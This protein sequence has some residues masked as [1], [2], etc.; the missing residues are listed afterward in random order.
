MAL[1]SFLQRKPRSEPARTAPAPEAAEALRARARRRLIGAALLLGLGV[2]VFGLLFETRPRPMPVDL[3]MVIKPVERL[4]TQG[5][6]PAVRPTAVQRA[7]APASAPAAAKGVETPAAAAP[8][9]AV[10]EPVAAAAPPASAQAPGRAAT[11]GGVAPAAPAASTPAAPAA[12]A[13]ADGKTARF[14]VQVG[15][16]AEASAAR[17][18]RLA[19]EKLGFKTYTQ[20]VETE[21]GKRTR[22]RVGPYASRDEAAKALAKIRAANLPGAVLAL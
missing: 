22:V 18:A 16:F 7:A 6:E 20:V 9:V 3:P 12:A 13:S 19:V 4:G 17:E 10:A 5:T 11:A 21:G 14:V 2:V 8:G 1:P 15:A